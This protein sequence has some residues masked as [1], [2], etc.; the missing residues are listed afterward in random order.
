M[1]QVLDRLYAASGTL[2]ALFIVSICMTVLVQVGFNLIDRIAQLTTGQAFGLV[3]PSYAEFTGFF[4]AAASFFALAD[5]LQS[6]NHIRVNLVIQRLPKRLRPYIEG[7]CCLLG[8]IVSG[9]FSFW[10]GNLV[11]ESFVFA[12]LSPGIIAVPLWIPQLAM[13]LGLVCLTVC[14]IDLFVQVVRGK[15]PSYLLNDET[16]SGGE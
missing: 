13:A 8:A 15:Q 9:Y 12:D 6:G 5:T 2:A 1:R 10:A 16:L 4:L 7:W 3:L 14:F 11:W